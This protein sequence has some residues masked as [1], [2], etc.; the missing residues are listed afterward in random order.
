MATWMYRTGDGPFGPMALHELEG[1][2]ASGQLAPETEV[3]DSLSNQWRPANE[4]EALAHSLALSPSR[5]N[6]LALQTHERR[7]RAWR[8]FWA[9]NL[10]LWIWGML[11]GAAVGVVLGVVWPASLD[12]LNHRGATFVLGIVMML[13]AMVIVDSVSMAVTGTTPGKALAGIRVYESN[14]R[15]LSL[16]TAMR[17]NLRVWWAGMA[18]GIPLIS[19]FA[20][21]RADGTLAYGQRT[22]WDEALDLLVI[23]SPQSWRT[24]LVAVVGLGAA[25]ADRFF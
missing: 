4:C 15:K 16:R 14:G 11:C 6:V 19:L 12:L 10:D 22:S 24:P 2:L 1:L 3:L 21:L 7:G 20:M 13:P 25:A 18:A 9:R 8:R 5:R 23:E 17:R